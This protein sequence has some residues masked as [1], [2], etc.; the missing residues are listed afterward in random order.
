MDRL[1]VY[2][3]RSTHQGDSIVEK[4]SEGGIGAAYP[5]KY[6]NTFIMVTSFCKRSLPLTS[7][8]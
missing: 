2:D 4:L 3:L 5:E 7:L 1:K 6:F 8:T